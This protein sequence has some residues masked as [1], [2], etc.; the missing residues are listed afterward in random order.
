MKPPAHAQEPFWQSVGEVRY[1]RHD[2]AGDGVSARRQPHRL[3]AVG[4]DRVLVTSVPTR[5]SNASRSSR[6]APTFSRSHTL[7]QN[8]RRQTHTVVQGSNHAFSQA[9]DEIRADRAIVPIL[10]VTG[11]VAALWSESLSTVIEIAQRD[12]AASSSRIRGGEG[13]TILALPHGT[14]VDC[15]SALGPQPHTALQVVDISDDVD[16]RTHRHRYLTHP[17]GGPWHTAWTHTAEAVAFL[18]Q[19]EGGPNAWWRTRLTWTSYERFAASSLGPSLLGL[20]WQARLLRRCLRAAPS[21]AAV[22]CC[23]S[24]QA[25]SCWCL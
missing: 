8:Q 16:R 24:W 20:S 17:R 25:P 7:R 12:D 6:W 11:D 2:N 5:P 9:I 18:Y 1:R 3:S 19:M 15:D 4:V 23:A 13:T 22:F 10:I 21:L 14:S